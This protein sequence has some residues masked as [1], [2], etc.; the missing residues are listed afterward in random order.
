M[1]DSEVVAAIVAG[2][3]AGLAAAYDKY[4]AS[5]YG[6]CRTLLREPA[7]AADA[8]QDT[9]VIAASRLSALRDPERLR[10]WLYAVARNEC[11][12]RLRGGDHAPLEQAPD[13]A[14]ESTDISHDT[15]RRE[16]NALIN[17]ALA[18]VGPAEREVLELQLRQGL[19]GGEVAGALGVTR[20]H[21]HALL[22]RARDQLHTSLGVL[23][24]ARTGRPDCPELAELLKDW[25]GQLTVLL[26]KRLNR[27]IAKC[28]IC[29]DRRRRELAPAMFLDL[30]PIAAL[31]ALA[32]S[33]P[34]SLRGQVLHAAGW[35]VPR[36]VPVTRSGFPKPLHRPKNGWLHSRSV[37]VGAA[38]ASAAGLAFAGT[39]IAAPTHHDSLH[40]S[41]TPA[42][43][44]RGTGSAAGKARPGRTVTPR[45]SAGAS[46]AAASSHGTP[47]THPAAG[48]SSGAASSSVGASPTA[49][50][51]VPASPSASSSAHSGTLSV[52]PA[53]IVLAPLLGGTLTLTAT[54]GPVTW[55]ISE[56][57]S[58]LGKLIVS[59]SSGTLAAGAS[60]TVTLSV[61][62]LASLDTQLSVA[63]SGTVVTVLLG[64]G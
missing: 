3:P 60:A 36:S 28:P 15:E 49:S 42:V 57:S 24:V 46:A 58:L 2:D 59:P 20:N 11:H 31:P 56:P 29:S 45:A 63:P 48:A 34:E 14:D 8:V 54:G 27:H 1:R 43:T 22:S 9:F 41:G 16:L 38:A 35:S 10:S 39:V 13:V 33:L 52:S 50:A 7:D 17:A 64:L 47:A 18:G 4:A 23:L 51:S 5:L 53:E 44:A 12:R 25:D 40:R 6:F 61:S 62:G 21:A 32:A 55:S 26:R 19:D 37:H 30:A